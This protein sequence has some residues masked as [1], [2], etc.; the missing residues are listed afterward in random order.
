MTHVERTAHM[1]PWSAA[2][3]ITAELPSGSWGALRVAALGDCCLLNH[4]GAA[5]RNKELELR[6][7]FFGFHGFMDRYCNNFY[8][9]SAAG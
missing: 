8:C 1:Q 9:R 6:W 3:T 7:L 5:T 4:W 2:A